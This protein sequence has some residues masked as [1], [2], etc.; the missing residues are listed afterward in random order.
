MKILFLDPV[1]ASSTRKREQE[2]QDAAAR[3]HAA[4]VAHRRSEKIPKLSAKQSSHASS[5]STLDEK[6]LNTIYPG[7]G[8]FRSELMSLLPSKACRGD[9]QALDFFVEV[10]MPGIDVANE[11]FNNSGAFPFLL[12]NLVSCLSLPAD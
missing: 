5:E 3:S 8:G 10:T 7:F 2:L 4:R 11:M 9:L 1:K 12:P 6:S